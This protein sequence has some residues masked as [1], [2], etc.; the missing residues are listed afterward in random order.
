MGKLLK[1]LK[2]MKKE[3]PTYKISG[4][5][6]DTCIQADNLVNAV[7]NT[8]NKHGININSLEYALD[9]AIIIY[10]DEMGRS[11]AIVITKED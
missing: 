5:S 9:R 7:K 6:L 11:Q 1:L 4:I 2:I 3:Q 8:I 10:D